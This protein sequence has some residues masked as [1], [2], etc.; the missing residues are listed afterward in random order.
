[1]LP[2]MDGILYT[3]SALDETMKRLVIKLR[4]H[5]KFVEPFEDML[6]NFESFK[7]LDLVRI[8]FEKGQKVGV[9]EV[10][11]KEGIRLKDIDLPTGYEILGILKEEG[12]K[13]VLMAKITAPKEMIPLFKTFDID[14]VWGTPLHKTKDEA[15]ISVMGSEEN[16]RKLLLALGRISDILEVS[17]QN[18]SF[19]SDDLLSCLTDKQREVMGAAR[20]SGYY[21][22]PRRIT[23]TQ[24][25]G[26]LGMSKA[27]ALEHLRKAEARLMGAI[28]S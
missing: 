25:A 17:V 24:L 11:L 12:S 21:Q 9:I 2:P 3:C 13:Y 19:S 18:P 28:L 20:D 22:Y 1:M 8:D 26:R 15:V 16:L 14:I 7:L 27:T 23:A 10:V 4:P 6:S 5:R